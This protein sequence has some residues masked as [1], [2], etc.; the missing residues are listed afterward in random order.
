MSALY[1]KSTTLNNKEF[2][3][4]GIIFNKELIGTVENI[5]QLYIL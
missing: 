3:N 5:E 4:K 2:D 1:S